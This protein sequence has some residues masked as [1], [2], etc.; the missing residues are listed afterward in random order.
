MGQKESAIRDDTGGLKTPRECYDDQLLKR[1]KNVYFDVEAWYEVI[2]SET[3]H[4]EF[5]LISPSM[6][7]AFVNFYQTRYISRKS[8]NSNDIQLIRSIQNQLKEQIFNS[9][10]TNGTFIRLSARSPKD[11]FAFGFSKDQSIL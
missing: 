10:I 5:I 2:Q 1:C 8:L 9:K 3:F 4:T 7:Q 11:G 6:A